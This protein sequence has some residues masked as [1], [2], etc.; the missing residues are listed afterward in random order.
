MGWVVPR[1]GSCR[2]FKDH[3]IQCKAVRF[4]QRAWSTP[5][6]GLVYASSQSLELLCREWIT[7]SSR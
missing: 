2:H 1:S 4:H 3:G 5:G 7:E 6:R